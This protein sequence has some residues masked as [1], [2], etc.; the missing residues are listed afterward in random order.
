VLAYMSQ[1]RAGATHNGHGR[2]TG[3]PR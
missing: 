3:V 1:A 2:L